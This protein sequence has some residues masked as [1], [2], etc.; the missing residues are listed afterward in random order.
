MFF[1][2]SWGKRYNAVTLARGLY[3]SHVNM[4]NIYIYILKANKYTGGGVLMVERMW[5]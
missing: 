4:K 3:I 5:V 2:G 1:R